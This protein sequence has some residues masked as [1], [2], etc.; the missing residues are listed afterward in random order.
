[1]KVE[2]AVVILCFRWP[3]RFFTSNGHGVAWPPIPTASLELELV[4]VSFLLKRRFPRAWS[5]TLPS[6]LP[7]LPRTSHPLLKHALDFFRLL[8]TTRNMP[9]RLLAPLFIPFRTC[10]VALLC[11]L[12]KVL[13]HTAKLLLGRLIRRAP[14]AA[15]SDV[16]RVHHRKRR[17]I[18][19]LLT[20]AKSGW[21]SDMPSL[22]SLYQAMESNHT[23]RPF[24]TMFLKRIPIKD[25]TLGRRLHDREL[26]WL[27]SRDLQISVA[28]CA[29]DVRESTLSALAALNQKTLL[30]LDVRGSRITDEILFK[31]SSLC[32]NLKSINLSSCR[33]LW[34][35]AVVALAER[36]PNL[37]TII[38]DHCSRIGDVAL[39]A[40]AEH[41]PKLR[42]LQMESCAIGD[43]S[44]MRLAES[45]P[46]LASISLSG[47]SKVGDKGISAL[48]YG[49]SQLRKIN[50]SGCD[51][52]S[53]A[54][55]ALADSS[56]PLTH[57]SLARCSRV[58]ADAWERFVMKAAK[59]I[60]HLNLNDCD[61]VSN[62]TV[63]ALADFGISLQ[64]VSLRHCEVT[65]YAALLLAHSSA[66]ISQL[67]LH[68]TRISNFVAQSIM[69][70]RASSKRKHH[71]QMDCS[72]CAMEER[73]LRYL[74]STFSF[75]L[76]RSSPES[77]R[78]GSPHHHTEHPHQQPNQ[79]RYGRLKAADVELVMR[80]AGC[81]KEEAVEAL[82]GNGE[83][84]IN[85][86]VDLIVVVQ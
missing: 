49:C 30:Q 50:F 45:C 19:T 65:D 21:L 23:L 4:D 37:H 77:S 15:L 61:G 28:R 42:T 43:I 9:L 55:L 73:S 31:V 39:W 41:C 34:S 79:Q 35:A 46:A 8:C 85:A 82:L 59:S 81:S 40:I 84:V 16:K 3:L 72:I 47:C 74:D 36:C 11:L 58:K 12:H 70:A 1:M 86:I 53:A 63:C 38:L 60:T 29:S 48:A 20:V 67:D 78:G 24:L 33:M 5:T 56:L 54:V 51:I 26:R 2:N 7:S 80:Q 83:N 6:L 69:S 10:L 66:N 76:Y 62:A 32:M 57:V 68:G 13:R 17:F 18:T 27:I 14:N 71:L 64:Q 44:V 22:I 25:L 52:S 75:D